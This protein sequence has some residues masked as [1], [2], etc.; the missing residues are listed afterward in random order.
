MALI[1]CHK[2]RATHHRLG[3]GA[4]DPAGRLGIEG[5]EILRIDPLAIRLLA[6]LKSGDGNPLP[7]GI[8][9]KRRAIL[10]GVIENRNREHDRQSLGD[11]TAGDAVDTGLFRPWISITRPVP[12]IGGGDVAEGLLPVR[13]V[14]HMIIEIKLPGL[15]RHHFTDRIP[16]GITRITR[17]RACCS[18]TLRHPDP[19]IAGTHRFPELQELLPALSLVDHTLGK[20]VPDIPRMTSEVDPATGGILDAESSRVGLPPEDVEGIDRHGF[21]KIEHHPLRM[22]TVRFAGVGV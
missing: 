10:R 6:K 2:T 19:E 21:S 16:H 17:T 11:A 4:A 13:A 18:G 22:T 9:C 8:R 20:G 7:A 12:R 14:D 15:A 1:E 5:S 3:V